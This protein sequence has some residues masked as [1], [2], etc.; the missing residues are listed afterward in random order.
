MSILNEI[1]II[2]SHPPMSIFEQLFGGLSSFIPTTAVADIMGTMFF[3][4]A[5][6]LTDVLLRIAI[7]CDGYLKASHKKYTLWNI[8]TTFLW[9]GW[10]ELPTNNGKKKRFLV[11]KGLRNALVMKITVQYPALFLFSTL[12]FLLPDVVVMGWRFDLMMSFVFTIIPVVCELTSIIEKLNLLDAD[13]V[14]IYGEFSKF[15]KSI[16]KE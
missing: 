14:K 16:R 4:I 10:G 3:T 15:V 7:E 11:S 9:Y 2:Q 13:L 12:S 5:L 6:L 1:M 8:L